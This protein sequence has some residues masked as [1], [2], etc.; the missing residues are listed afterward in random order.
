VQFGSWIATPGPWRALAG[1]F[2]DDGCDTISIYSPS[3]Q[4]ICVINE[5]GSNGGG[6]GSADYSFVFGNP[7]DK[8]FTGD[9]N[10]NRQDTVG[11]RREST[12]FLYYRDTLTTGNA[13][14]DFFFGNPDDQIN[15][16]R[17]IWSPICAVMGGLEA[18]SLA[19]VDGTKC[20]EHAFCGIVHVA[21]H[22]N[23]CNVTQSHILAERPVLLCV[24]EVDTESIRAG[25]CILIHE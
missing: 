25:V 11:L 17:R 24:S 2:N 9:F 10:N 23:C 16:G 19:V 14:N 12:G 1:D 13:D 7:G 3:Q 18:V 20:F 6:S 22:V 21:Q 15:T 8:P 5:L 4:R